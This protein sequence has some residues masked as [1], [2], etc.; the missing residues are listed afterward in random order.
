MDTRHRCAGPSR[1]QILAG[2]AATPIG[3]ALRPQPAFA[4]Q[5]PIPLNRLAAKGINVGVRQLDAE[6]WRRAVEADPRLPRSPAELRRLWQGLSAHRRAPGLATQL[7]AEECGEHA[8]GQ[9]FTGLG[10]PLLRQRDR[11]DLEAMIDADQPSLGETLE[12]ENFVLR[13][14]NA[15]A[16]PGD[17]I[18]DPAI[19]KETAGYLEAARAR[20][21]TVFGRAPYTLPGASKIEVAFTDIGVPLGSSTPEGPI[22]LNSAKWKNRGIRRPTSAHELFHKL[23]YAFGLRTK[24]HGSAADKWFAEGT[25]SW[26][27]VFM[28]QRV[29]AGYKITDLFTHPDNSLFNAE[30]KALP[31]WLFFDTHLRGT[32]D[33]VPMLDYLRRYHDSGKTVN[34]LTDAIQAD[35][36]YRDLD[37]F[38]AL[39]GRERRTGHWRVTPAGEQLYPTICGPED[40][41]LSPS[42]HMTEV[43][44]AMGALPLNTSSVSKLGSDY[45]HFALGPE[46]AGKLLKVAVQA[47]PGSDFSYYLIWEKGGTLVRTSFPSAVTGDYSF[48]KRI[49]PAV[50]DGLV[51]IISGRSTGGDYRMKVEVNQP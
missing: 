30:Y 22:C 33:H 20:Y 5:P 51:L 19:V 35:D 11:D 16:H 27:E 31:F 42:V 40:T 10:N 2:L 47:R 29:S 48:S 28:W 12:T 32:A 39:F 45:Y 50:A 44:M 25:A 3:F 4:Q 38:F 24:Y 8:Y 34:A 26:A 43:P 7:P 49:D 17:N 46:Y 18:S 9:F 41:V 13:W 36:R 37:T 15:S 14:T 1:R 6:A 23:Q 21:I